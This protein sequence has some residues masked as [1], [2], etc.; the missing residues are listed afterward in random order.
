ML[1]QLHLILTYK[2]TFECDHCFCYSSPRA[3]G[4]MSLDQ[5]KI[6][7][8]EAEKIGS[9]VWIYFEGGEPFLYYPLLIEGIKLTLAKG[10]KVG[11]V[12]NGYWA[13]SEKDALF[14]LRPLT[15]HQVHD[16]SIS[17]DSFHYEEGES[18]SEN[19][20]KA[21]CKLGIPSNSICIEKPFAAAE[22][23]KGCGKG[24]PVVG[25]NVLFKGRAADKLTDGYPR[26]NKN[27]LTVCPYEDLESPERVHIDSYGNIH[28]CQ[29]L[30]MGN[31]YRKRLSEII[32]EY[33]PHAHPICGPLI[34]GGPAFLAKEHN[35]NQ[36]E[37]YVDECHYCFSVRRKLIEHFP[38]YLAPRQVYGL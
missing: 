37:E 34:E 32:D 16:L 6:I 5:I 13:T 22:L 10:F 28:L 35:V 12:T 31:M 38:E 15:E 29:G 36:E 7:L 1:T 25:G 30:S 8:N 4:T 3:E 21:A 23:E 14:W 27:E 19:A 24:Q 18:L 11:I 2:C 9:I 20:I 33:D 17:D 26:L